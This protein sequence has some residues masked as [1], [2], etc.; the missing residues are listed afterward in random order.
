MNSSVGINVI[1]RLGGKPA[2]T[3]PAFAEFA[4]KVGYAALWD[5]YGPPD[6]CRKDA[7]GDYRCE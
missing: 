7:N 3:S 2:R 1:W 4:R 5:Q 6:L